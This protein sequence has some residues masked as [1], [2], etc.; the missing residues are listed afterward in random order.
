MQNELVMADDD[1]DDD[2]DG[3]DDDDDAKRED[4]HQDKTTQAAVLPFGCR[5]RHQGPQQPRWTKI[6][7]TNPRKL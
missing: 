5:L 4:K 1:D 2:D 7:E 3:D 6:T